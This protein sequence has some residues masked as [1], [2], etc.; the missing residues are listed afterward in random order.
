MTQDVTHESMRRERHFAALVTA[1]IAAVLM[2]VL[3]MPLS[4]SPAYA[5][6]NNPEDVWIPPQNT[7]PLPFFNLFGGGQRQQPQRTQEQ[8]READEEHMRL[9]AEARAAAAA[10][11]RDRMADQGERPTG[12][13]DTY[14]VIGDSLAAQLAEGLIDIHA[15]ERTVW[16]EDRTVGFSGLFGQEEHNWPRELQAIFR[17][18]NP[19]VIFVMLGVNDRQSIAGE[20]GASLSVNSPAWQTDYIGRIDALLA[21]LVERRTPVIWVGL[22]PVASQ[23]AAHDFNRF[24]AIYRQRVEAAGFFFLDIWD[25]FAD[26]NGQYAAQGPNVEGEIVALREDD[27]IH[28][29]NQGK[30]KLAFFAERLR[31]RLLGATGAG[32]LSGIAPLEVDENSKRRRVVLT[33]IANRPGAILS[34][35]PEARIP[36]PFSEDGSALPSGQN[37]LANE[38]MRRNP[39]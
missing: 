5:Q 39:L 3:L 8:Q 35:G 11:Q 20:D 29:R 7:T 16:I 31:R 1:V 22:P 24:N 33:G 13:H 19:R 18:E 27:G 2:L 26:A 14:L 6:F 12:M 30:K 17:E 21:V 32:A 34:G 25:G 28:F 10:N 37:S 36:S 38:V 4:A 9:E 15:R 23:A